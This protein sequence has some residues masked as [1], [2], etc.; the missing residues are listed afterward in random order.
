MFLP[1]GIVDYCPAKFML[2][3]NRPIRRRSFLYSNT[4]A[5]HP[6]FFEIVKAIWETHF[7]GCWMFQ[8]VRK[9]KLLKELKSL[10]SQGYRNIGTEAN[11]NREALVQV[12]QL[13]QT[14]PQCS[15]LQQVNKRDIKFRQSSFLETEFVS[16][17]KGK[18]NMD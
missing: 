6:K 7:H 5:H 12:Q 9:L 13:L 17:K 8:V 10:N 16:T 3:V 15:V 11:E 1:E 14:S 2:S 18:C 4:W